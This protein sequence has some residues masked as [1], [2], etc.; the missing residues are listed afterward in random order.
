VASVFNFGGGFDLHYD[1]GDVSGSVYVAYLYA[2]SEDLSVTIEIGSIAWRPDFGPVWAGGQAGAIANRLDSQDP[3]FHFPYV[4]FGNS[5][6]DGYGF[7]FQN[8]EDFNFR[9]GVPSGADP[10][11]PPL[12]QPSFY[13]DPTPHDTEALIRKRKGEVP[14]ANA[15]HG[16]SDSGVIPTSAK[17]PKRVIA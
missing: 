5:T 9:I 13:P 12:S 7:I 8:F 15:A 3:R 14:V 6:A 11:P 1:G 2:D 16:G 4:I 10:S 17:R